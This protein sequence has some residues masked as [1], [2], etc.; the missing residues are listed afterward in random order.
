MPLLTP[1]YSAVLETPDSYGFYRQ[2][3]RVARINVLER[4]HRLLAC[5]ESAPSGRSVKQEP[6]E[7]SQAVAA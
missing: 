7:A 6:A 5:G 2:S 4:G 1:E 3:I